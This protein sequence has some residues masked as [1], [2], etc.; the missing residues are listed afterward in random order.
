M[1]ALYLDPFDPSQSARTLWS[2]QKE[3][4]SKN[5]KKIIHVA[6]LK[7]TQFAICEA[8]DVFTS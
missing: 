2:S 4:N 7:K 1:Y 6:I 3:L 8:I 5:F